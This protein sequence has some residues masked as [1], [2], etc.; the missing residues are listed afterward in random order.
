V[1]STLPSS[2]RAAAATASSARTSLTPPALPR[3]PAWIC[4]LTAQAEPPIRRA[5]STASAAV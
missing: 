3:P 5:A 2:S 4:A 1:T